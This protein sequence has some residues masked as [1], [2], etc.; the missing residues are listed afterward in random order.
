[1][2]KKGKSSHSL[3]RFK[4]A[5]SNLEQ[6]ATQ[7]ENESI[8]NLQNI[9][10]EGDE[11]IAKRGS[12][13]ERSVELTRSFFQGLFTK[14]PTGN[15][16]NHQ[17][18]K[19]LFES[20]QF[21]K[22]HYR[23]LHKLEEGSNE[24]KEVAEWALDAILRYNN[25]VDKKTIT[26]NLKNRIAC[27]VLKKSGFQL[28]EELFQNRIEI[29]RQHTVEY[30]TVE[31]ETQKKMGS[32]L[33]S[34]AYLPTRS[35]MDLLRMKSLS[36]AKNH[37]KIP[38]ALKKTLFSHVL[39]APIV[40]SEKKME[41]DKETV[42]EMEQTFKAL[43]GE[44]IKVKG[45]FKRDENS[46]IT[47]IAIPDSFSLSTHSS[48]TG[49]PD[50]SQHTGVSFCDTLLPAL[51]LRMDKL[52][53]YK[54]VYESK[55]EIARGLL[56]NG[57]YNE[58]A[59]KHLLLKRETFQK[60]ENE[61]QAAHKKWMHTVFKASKEECSID[62][63]R[64][65]FSFDTLTE[66]YHTLSEC[67][68]SSFNKLHTFALDQHHE[69]LLQKE[70]KLR[71]EICQNFLKE[72]FESIISKPLPVSWTH[73]MGQLLSKAS[74]PILLQQLSEKVGF[75]P[76]LMRE[77]ERKIQS[78]AFM[79]LSAFCHELKELK[80]ETHEDVLENLLFQLEKETHLFEVESLE[81][82]DD[83]SVQ[84]VQEL[85]FYYNSQYYQ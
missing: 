74:V 29:P 43:P 71:L 6:F 31:K 69:E 24:E 85:E 70:G 17:I 32:H 53:L 36:L 45:F 33:F 42:V 56:P 9:D 19:K 34:K 83:S 15:K 11:I 37:A 73:S 39:R 81:L 27:F 5:V 41:E 57:Q 16:K 72:E 54:K 46:L 68:K 80:F 64:T 12:S 1:M 18:Q 13:L 47:S 60:Y 44:V 51:P 50:P 78:W 52:V 79:Q 22:T 3:E 59:K 8:P 82:F 10:L 38:D 58:I 23:I 21:L 84:V 76:P 35:E 75:A 4:K 77:F 40:A 26:K 49:F 14:V 62:L 2:K 61:L 66:T 63:Q 20:I 48:Q 25:V 55:E 30:K 28:D 7:N 67:M 65:N